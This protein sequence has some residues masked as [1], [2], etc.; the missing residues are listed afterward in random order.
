MGGRRGQGDG[1]GRSP[2]ERRRHYVT[3]ADVRED[4]TRRDT[5]REIRSSHKDRMTS[6][7]DE[8]ERETHTYTKRF[9][10]FRL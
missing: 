8:R 5:K 4:P 9:T 10:K 7:R 6:R 1:P 2:E 3:G